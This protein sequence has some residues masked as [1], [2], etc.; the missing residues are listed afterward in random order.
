MCV[1]DDDVIVIDTHSLLDLTPYTYDYTVFFLLALSSHKSN[2][3][4]TINKFNVVFLK[5]TSK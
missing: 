3:N 4:P 2:S 5:N 1:N